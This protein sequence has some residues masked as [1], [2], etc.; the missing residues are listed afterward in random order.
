MKIEL[1]KDYLE[2]PKGKIIEVDND[3]ANY[4]IRC[5]VAKIYSIKKAKK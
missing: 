5:K 2:L 1:L 3:R 4:L